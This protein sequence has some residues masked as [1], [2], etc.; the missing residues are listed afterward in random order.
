MA[1]HDGIYHLIKQ[2]ITFLQLPIP[3]PIH[4]PTLKTFTPYPPQHNHPLPPTKPP[5]PFHPQLDQEQLRTLSIWI[6]LKSNIL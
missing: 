3:L 2:P 6:T 5:V 1:F 4:D